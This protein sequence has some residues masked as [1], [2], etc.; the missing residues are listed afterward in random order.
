MSLASGALGYSV[1]IPTI[2][3]EIINAETPPAGKSISSYVALENKSGNTYD[4]T[5]R[6]FILGT[7]V[8][9]LIYTWIVFINILINVYFE[10]TFP[11]ATTIKEGL[12]TKD[13]LSAIY[14][15]LILCVLVTG[16]TFF[17][18]NYII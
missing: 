4:S 17:V 1:V 3:P 15:Q 5:I 13:F 2:G 11:T 14:K 9:L 18:L 7:F 8:F 16:L 6:L 10:S 12:G